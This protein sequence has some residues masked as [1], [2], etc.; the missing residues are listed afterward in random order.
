M[1]LHRVSGARLAALAL[2]I[3]MPFAAQA[4]RAKQ[5]RSPLVSA[6]PVVVSFE[7][8]RSAA[9][10]PFELDGNTIVVRARVNDSAL[11]KFIFDT[12]AGITLFNAQM[13]ESMGLKYQ[14][15]QVNVNG[16]GGSL[17]GKLLKEASLSLE[18]VKVTNQIMTTLSFENFPCEYQNLGGVLGYDFIKEFVVEIDY[19]S[20]TI[21][22]FDPKTYT[23]TGRGETIPLMLDRTPFVHAKIALEA[24]KPIEGL[25]E[26]DTGSDGTLSVNTP[27]VKKHGLLKAVQQQMKNRQR[28]VGGKSENVEARLAN[29]QLGS[30]VL[31][32]PIVSFSLA[33]AGTL[34]DTDN[35]GPLGNE[36]LRRFKVTLDYSRRRM[37]LEPNEG[38]ADSFE[39]N[40]SGIQIETSGAGCK[41]VTVESVAPESPAAEAGVKE[42]DLI[43]AIDGQAI[44]RFTSTQIEEMFRR[45]GA[46][47]SL[48]LKRGKQQLLQV[49]LKLRRLI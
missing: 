7:A 41:T 30:F 45:E 9:K 12:G 15:V 37:M 4:Q 47:H 38:L 33:T 43:L 18:G 6:Q 10:I 29:L 16:I 23:Y 8:G 1:N 20:K 35:D 40:M 11:L 17:G 22:L 24:G 19:Q 5:K 46:E 42:G 31:Q 3:S 2:L 25:F 26:I 21:S 27:F 13:A 28:G 32:N 44:E 34:T 49:K 39:E 14:R 48:S 36:I